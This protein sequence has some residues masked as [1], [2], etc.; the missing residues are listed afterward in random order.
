[1]QTVRAPGQLEGRAQRRLG[2]DELGLAQRSPRRRSPPCR[3]AARAPA[4]RAPAPAR[5]RRTARA[6]PARRRAS[7][8]GS[9][10]PRRRR[11]T[12]PTR[13]PSAR[14]AAA[15]RAAARGARDARPRRRCRRARPWMRSV[16]AVPPPVRWGLTIPFAGL[17][18]RDHR[19]ALRARRGRRPSTTSGPARPPAPTASPRSR[20][21]PPW[22]ERLR[23]ATGIVNPFT[24]GLPVLAQHAAALQ[25]ASSGRFV[26]G[27][28]S[29]SNVIVERWNG[30]PFTKPLSKMREALEM[31]RPVLAGERGP[32]GFR[33]EQPPETPPPLIV[34]ALRGK[35][36]APRR[37]ARRRRVHQLP[38]AQRREPGRRGVRR[39]RQGARLPLLLRP[40]SPPR[41]RCR[42]R[43]ACSPPTR[44]VP[45]Y[46]EFFRWLGWA[47]RIDP[48]VKAWHDGDRAA[49][50]RARARR[51]GARDLR[52]RRPRGAAR[53]P[54]A[55]RRRGH[56]D[57][58]AHARSAAPDQLPDTIRALAR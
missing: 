30:V 27:L 18:L 28:G 51:P 20:S 43:G 15:P 53:A 26:L 1:M 55:V 13:G 38:A 21:P 14:A 36:L 10:R 54:R 17:P 9:T 7:R 50:A 56:H 11:A 41:R 34:A 16:P 31:L 5:S 29:S 58:R 42:S 3:A 52:L 45:V 44:T 4:S 47:E 49:R 24:R 6:G 25:D 40:R 19:A 39:A 12:P 46:T 22:T 37:R 8:R 57:V 2:L 32:G 48:M 33:L 35:M 23:L